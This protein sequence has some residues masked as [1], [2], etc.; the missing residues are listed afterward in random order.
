MIQRV[1]TGPFFAKLIWEGDSKMENLFVG[2]R[3]MGK[4][5][6][7][8]L[9]GAL[10]LS[11]AAE[12]KKPKLA[13]VLPSQVKTIHLEKA[14]KAVTASKSTALSDYAPELQAEARDN[15]SA[16]KYFSRSVFFFHSSDAIPDSYNCDEGIEESKKQ[17]AQSQAESKC[18]ANGTEECRVAK[19]VISKSGELQCSDFP[20]RKC[21]ARGHYRGCVAEALVLG[22]KREIT[23]DSA[24]N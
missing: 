13:H 12:A 7:I 11:G 18:A 21:P 1:I 22:D 9:L 10:T 23:P 19:V 17:E 24:S 16:S 20:G 3:D 15:P 2:V 5:N 6:S 14:R 4:I 8:I